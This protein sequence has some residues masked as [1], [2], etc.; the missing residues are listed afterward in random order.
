MSF[1][2][3]FELKVVEIFLNIDFDCELYLKWKS[4]RMISESKEK[5][6]L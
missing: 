5:I 6:K 2:F 3:K 1:N 4:S